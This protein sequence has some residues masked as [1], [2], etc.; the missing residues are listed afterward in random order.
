MTDETQTA[1]Q[2]PKDGTA[3]AQMGRRGGAWR[4]PECH[5]VF[6]DTATMRGGRRGRPPVWQPVLMSV[7]WS[8]IATVVARKLLRRP[9]PQSRA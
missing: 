1:W 2:C 4:C 7:F 5:G 3:M 8:V 6:I 9:R